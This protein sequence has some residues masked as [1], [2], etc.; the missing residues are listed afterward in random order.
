MKKILIILLALP[1]ALN[2]QVLVNKNKLEVGAHLQDAMNM[3]SGFNIGYHTNN[4]VF[5]ISYGTQV[6]DGEIED[7]VSFQLAAH[8]EILDNLHIIPEAEVWL[9][10]NYGGAAMSLNVGVTMFKEIYEACYETTYSVTHSFMPIV[11]L[12]RKTENYF[13]NR[14]ETVWQIGFNARM[15]N[16]L[17]VMRYNQDFRIMINYLIKG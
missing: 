8:R 11:G 14:K 13:S 15:S 5:R 7:L 6:E 10:D 2:S 16:I 17:V 3:F 12:T 9:H 4:S 1:L